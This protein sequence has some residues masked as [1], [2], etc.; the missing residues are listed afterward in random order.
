MRFHD[1]LH[2]LEVLDL[3]EPGRPRRPRL[4]TM[5]VLEGALARGLEDPDFRLDCIELDLAAWREW[6]AS[7]WSGMKPPIATVPD[8]GFFVMMF[9]WPPG[10]VAPPHEHTSWTMSAVFHNRLEVMTYDWDRAVK[11]RRLER[12]NLFVAEA[13]KVG[14]IHEPAI[15]SPRNA[16]TSGTTS[17]HIYNSD[18]GAVLEKQVGPIEGLDSY[19]KTAAVPPRPPALFLRIRQS[20][21][22]AHAEAAQRFPSARAMTVLETL[23]RLGDLATRGV[24]ARSMGA[25]DPHGAE[26]RL[27]RLSAE[28]DPVSLRRPAG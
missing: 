4:E 20:V 11:T 28:W 6:E 27:E 2:L 23:Y 18:D 25:L 8:L 13:G 22:R 24:V 16:T 7:G 17:F 21:Y 26:S 9:F 12:K 19:D 5:R 1:L 3:G 15:H 14:F 10:E